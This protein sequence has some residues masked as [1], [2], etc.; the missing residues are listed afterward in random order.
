MISYFLVTGLK[1]SCLR[2]SLAVIRCLGS[3]A[4]ILL[5]KSKAKGLS[6]IGK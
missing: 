2:A 3:R 5:S 1:K 4:N 6:I